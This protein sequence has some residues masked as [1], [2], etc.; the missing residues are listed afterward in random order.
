M[1]RKSIRENKNEYQLS[2]E[3]AGLTRAEAAELME[4]VSES[5]IEKIESEKSEPH[6]DEIMAMAQAYKKPSLCNYYCSTQC[7]LGQERIAHVEIKD[8]SQITLEMLATLNNLNK[9][10]DRLI[11]ITADGVISNDEMED[12]SR[13]KHQ[14]SQIARTADSLQ[15]WIENTIAAGGLDA[16]ALK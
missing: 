10:K 11:E 15:L 8:L 14:L 9:E 3:A 7:P 16:E 5:R 1:G 2:R 13:I 6:P 4:Y 12:F